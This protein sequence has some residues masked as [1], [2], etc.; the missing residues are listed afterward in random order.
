MYFNDQT[1]KYHIDNQ[2]TVKKQLELSG[3]PVEQIT[4][5]QTCTFQDPNGF[6]YR[7]DKQCGRHLSFIVRKSD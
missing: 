6:S 7:E 4:I 3:I 1:N 5:D 2:L